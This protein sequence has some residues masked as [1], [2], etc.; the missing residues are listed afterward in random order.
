MLSPKLLERLFKGLHQLL[1]LSEAQEICFEANPATFTATKVQLFKDL[2]ISRVSLG[3]QSFSDR[4]LK[5]LG[6]EHTR[7][8]AIESVEI[9]QAVGIPQVNI[10]L[11]FAVPGQPFSEWEDTLRTAISLNP[12]HISSYN[13]TYE[14]DTEFIEKLTRGE[15]QESEENNADYFRLSHD[16]LTSAGFIHYETSNYSKPGFA[17]RHNMSYWKGK[18]YIGIGPSAVGTLHGQ[19]YR[20]IPDTAKYLQ[21]IQSLGHAKHEIE[22]IDAEAYRL[23]RIALLLRTQE[24]LDK[25]WLN[26]EGLQQVELLQ[27]EG[28]I[29][30]TGENIQLINEGPLLVD[31]IVERLI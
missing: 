23:E 20:N 30:I 12:H 19:R 27:N 5:I 10:D 2:G 21:M 18:D 15:F 14:E 17:S 31:P 25:K 22:T 7:T 6:R 16:L 9:L 29:K 28:L 4:V 11:M 24:G 13:L 3:I 26:E 8:Q 1:D